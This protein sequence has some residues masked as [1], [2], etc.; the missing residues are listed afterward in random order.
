M[1]DEFPYP[2]HLCPLNK[3]LSQLMKARRNL[4]QLLNHHCAILEMSCVLS[5]TKKSYMLIKG[6]ME[7]HL[8]TGQKGIRWEQYPEPESTGEPKAGWQE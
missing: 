1:T 2:G 8:I 5:R 4:D 7:V 6:M 3:F